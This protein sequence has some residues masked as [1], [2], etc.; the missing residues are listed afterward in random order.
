MARRVAGS[1]P[2][3]ASARRNRGSVFEA[4]IQALLAFT[5]TQE[6]ARRVETLGGY[7]VSGIGSIRWNG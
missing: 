1:R 3:S 4:P 6:F 2:T 5:R 7:D